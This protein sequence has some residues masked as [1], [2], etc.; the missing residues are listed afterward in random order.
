M[1]LPAELLGAISEVVRIVIF[2][3][4]AWL[5][6]VRF[7]HLDIVFWLILSRGLLMTVSWEGWEKYHMVLIASLWYLRSIS[8]LDKPLELFGL[9]ARLD[10]ETGSTPAK[11]SRTA[12]TPV[13]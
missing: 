6:C 11:P 8:E 2:A 1:L 9:D 4:L 13:G 3:A 5:T 7:R 12:E 10:R